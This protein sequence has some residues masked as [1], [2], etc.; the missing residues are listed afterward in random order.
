MGNAARLGASR[1]PKSEG[2]LGTSALVSGGNRYYI[3]IINPQLSLVTD[4][5]PHYINY[6]KYNIITSSHH[7]NAAI[8]ARISIIA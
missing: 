3:K 1:P 2:G 7:G 6:I 5:K 8:N 4:L